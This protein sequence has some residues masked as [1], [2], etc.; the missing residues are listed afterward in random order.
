M[1]DRVRDQERKEKDDKEKKEK[2]ELETEEN[3]D[4]I[5]EDHENEEEEEELLVGKK[6]GD[7]LR[8][9]I[10]TPTRELAMQIKNHIQ[11]SLFYIK[12]YLI[13]FKG[14]GSILH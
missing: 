12:R 7:K 4:E 3:D 8:A 9:L 1:N 10:L 14:K 11:V 5:D 2:M 6:R 13:E